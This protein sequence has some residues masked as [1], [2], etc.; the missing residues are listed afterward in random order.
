ML[1]LVMR[2]FA[3]PPEEPSTIA[4]PLADPQEPPAPADP[5]ELPAT[6]PPPADLVDGEAGQQAR[7]ARRGERQEAR[8]ERQERTATFLENMA[9]AQTRL[10]EGIRLTNVALSDSCSTLAD[11]C[12]LQ[13]CNVVNG[14]PFPVRVS[15]SVILRDNS[16]NLWTSTVSSD[17]PAQNTVEIS[18]AFFEPRMG[19][20]GY[21]GSCTLKTVLPGP[22]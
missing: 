15:V 17:V 4:P 22:F 19:F 1:L 16:G 9:D 5:Q 13:R 12:L 7:D 3:D 14:W 6:A 21:V 2:A 20:Y 11:Y 8:A 10:R 18:H